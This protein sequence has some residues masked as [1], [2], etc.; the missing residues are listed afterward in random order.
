MMKKKNQYQ[1]LDMSF[2]KVID[3]VIISLKNETCSEDYIMI[4]EYTFCNQEEEMGKQ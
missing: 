1:V 2:D 3:E 4:F